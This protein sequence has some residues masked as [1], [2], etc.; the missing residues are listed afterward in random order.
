DTSK[1]A[2]VDKDSTNISFASVF[3]TISNTL[4]LQFEKTEE[5]SYNVS[6]LPQTFRDIFGDTNDSLNYRLVTPKQSTFGNVRIR[7]INATYPV[8]VQLT[9]DKWEVIYEQ[10]STKPEV[11]DFLNVAPSN[12]KIRIIHDANGNG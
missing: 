9:N 4:S 8:I 10:Y 2:I 12:Y 6:V 1:I 5:N 7:L 3:D 11:L